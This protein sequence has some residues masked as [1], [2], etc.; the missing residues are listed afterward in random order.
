MRETSC[1]VIA[2]HEARHAVAAWAFGP[3]PRCYPRGELGAS[4]DAAEDP[5]RVAPGLQ[6]FFF[7]LRFW[8]PLP[9]LPCWCWA[10]RWFDPPWPSWGIPCGFCWVPGLFSAI[11]KVSL[12]ASGAL[13][14]SEKNVG[15]AIGSSV[16]GAFAG[17]AP[18]PTRK[19]RPR[20][21]GTSGRGPPL[22]SD[23]APGMVS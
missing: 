3:H 11:A 15:A 22:D 20:G 7:C 16:A 13:P 2:I 17:R 12:V 4:Y 21:G 1:E 14:G 6:L 9:S 23:P 8:A 5:L 18:G 19:G 10:P